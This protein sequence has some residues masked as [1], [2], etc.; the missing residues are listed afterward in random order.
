MCLQV[1]RAVL[2]ETGDVVA[3][4]VQFPTLQRDF[5]A[6]ML[7]HRIVLTMAGY[8][9]KGVLFLKLISVKRTVTLSVKFLGLF[10]GF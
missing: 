2:R 7:I 4:K 6:D 9:F 3:V 8:F 10:G 1:H 5:Y